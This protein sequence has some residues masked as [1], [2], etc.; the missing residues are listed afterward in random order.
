MNFVHHPEQLR[1]SVQHRVDSV[2]HQAD[3]VLHSPRRSNRT[4]FVLNHVQP[5]LLQTLT[6]HM[7]VIH[8]W[9]S[10]LFQTAEDAAARLLLSGLD[11]V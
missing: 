9:R 4:R 11:R 2:V 7:Q 6:Q 10:S 1:E 5:L 3:G 8:V